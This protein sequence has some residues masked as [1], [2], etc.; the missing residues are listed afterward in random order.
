MNEGDL[1]IALA[2]AIREGRVLVDLDCRKLRHIDSPITVEADYNR[3]VYAVAVVAA[4]A[5]IL[6][7]WIAGV[8]ALAVGI[9]VY[10]V[11]GQPW[12]H[13][14]MRGRFH[15]QILRDIKLFKKLWNLKG[16]TL[17]LPAEAGA[18]A[19]A[20]CA[21]PDGNWRRFVLDQL[22]PPAM[23]PQANDFIP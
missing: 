23:A 22:I 6:V 2:L 5:G 12:V 9:A 17:I 18:P 16:V 11:K 15:G 13:A 14:R 8:S 4:A 20:T 19:L 7:N 21:S 1:F 3:W 10:F